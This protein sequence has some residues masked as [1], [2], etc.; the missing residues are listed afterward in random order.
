M[1][2]FL[3]SNLQLLYAA[4]DVLIIEK[5]MINVAERTF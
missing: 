2:T 1:F 5:G 3:F 4:T